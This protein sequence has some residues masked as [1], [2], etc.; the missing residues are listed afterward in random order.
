[1][2]GRT[3]TITRRFLDDLTGQNFLDELGRMRKALLVCHAPQD[4]YVGIDNATAIFAAARHPKNL[5]RKPMASTLR[6]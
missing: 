2:A 1:L 6:T 4:E 3:F 5:L